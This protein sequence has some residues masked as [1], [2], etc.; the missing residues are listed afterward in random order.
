MA[1]LFIGGAF[2]TAFSVEDRTQ[3]S[4][5]P[6]VAMA[7]CVAV[8]PDIAGGIVTSQPAV[9][10]AIAV[11]VSPDIPGGLVTSIP[12]VAIMTAVA[13]SPVSLPSVQTRAAVLG[14]FGFEPKTLA[15]EWST[16]PKAVGSFGTA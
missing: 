12:A 8:S 7:T 4:S 14:T 6:A 16:E 2:E 1:G 9:A 11:A 3:E 10:V 5:A 15:D 13:I